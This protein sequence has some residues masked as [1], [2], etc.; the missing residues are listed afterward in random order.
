LRCISRKALKIN[1]SSN[2]GLN[3]KVKKKFDKANAIDMV[4]NI[5]FEDPEVERICH[6]HGVYTY[7]DAAK[8]TSI[9][10]GDKNRVNDSWFYFSKIETF[11]E[12]RYFTGLSELKAFSFTNCRKLKVLYIPKNISI[13]KQYSLSDCYGL[14]EL[15]IYSNNLKLIEYNSIS[16]SQGPDIYMRKDCP[17]YEPFYKMTKG[18]NKHHL[19]EYSDFNIFDLSQYRTTEGLS[20][21]YKSLGLNKKVQK[22][23]D[24][25]DAVD[26]ISGYVDL[27]LP[28]GN[29]WAKYNVGSDDIQDYGDYMSYDEAVERGLEDT[30]PTE[31]DWEE[32]TDNCD[33]CFTEY[34]AGEGNGLLLMSKKDKSKEIFFPAG[35]HQYE[36]SKKAWGD[37]A[38]GDYLINGSKGRIKCFELHNKGIYT[39]IYGDKNVKCLVR[40]VSRRKD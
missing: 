24:K 22:K 7:D 18:P 31:K 29:L 1:E 38:S 19:Y 13:I 12:F 26:N 32:L 40:L 37:G 33:F 39:S 6:E 27:G 9:F 25:I 5:Q 36:T 16:V 4:S 8:V 3:N 10:N 34:Y 30:M 23:F 21:N 20:E 14:E 11:K 28:S 2:L 15:V 17:A 35:G